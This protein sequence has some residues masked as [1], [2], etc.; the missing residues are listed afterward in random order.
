[1]AYEFKYRLLETPTPTTSGSGLVMHQLVP[2]YRTADTQEDWMEMGAWARTVPVPD[3]A[4]KTINDMP[5]TTGAL[6]A[7]KNAAYKA[8][9]A[10]H[11]N[12]V[13]AAPAPDWSLAGL[14]RFL[15]ANDAATLEA[16]RADEYITV[17]LG[18]E[19]PVD[20]VV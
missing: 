3:G 13:S 5:H 16:Q 2:I 6:K 8:A 15:A 18:Q 4:L 20:F 11:L 10:D 19:Y 14:A 12:D 7:A 1:M 9:L 17:T